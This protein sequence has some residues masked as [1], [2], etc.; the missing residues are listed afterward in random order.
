[1]S[2]L[3][4]SLLAVGVVVIAAV[5]VYNWL[6]ERKFRKMAQERFQAPRQDV[7][8][9]EAREPLTRDTLDDI[10]VEPRIEPTLDPAAESAERAEQVVAVE[11]E[12]VVAPAVVPRQVSGPAD[13]SLP[14][15]LDLAI[16]YVARL[17]LAD[18]T[19]ASAVRAALGAETVDKAVYW[20]GLNPAG[21]WEEVSTA[22]DNVPFSTLVG[23]VQLADR[24]GALTKE[25]LARFTLQAQQAAEILMAVAQLPDRAAALEQ[26]ERLDGFCADVDIL[27][28]INV[29]ALEQN[30]FAGTKIRALA[31]AAGLTL[32]SDGTFQYRDDKGQVLY[33][34]TNQETA[35][36]QAG[37]IKSLNTHGLTLLFEV[38]R[39]PNGLRVFDQMILFAHQ[40]TE[41][42]K[43]MVVDDNL[44]PLSDE[45][46]AKIKQQLS[47]VYGKMDKYGIPA[48]SP[49]AL[50]LFS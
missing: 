41:S 25:Q 1:M 27:V 24:G 11:E 23:S 49:R 6:Q 21:Q 31:E 12:P 36:F 30:V 29:V 2:D 18:P 40:L 47:L 8:M 35:P 38:P 7:L 26:A 22:R 28:G 9:E 44:R 4:L 20:K 33:A 13:K 15:P 37:D 17:D 46:I 19:A 14:A 43:A 45:G 48:G 34:L 3:H 16:D 50:R 32:A 39:V 42:L 5:V 10:R